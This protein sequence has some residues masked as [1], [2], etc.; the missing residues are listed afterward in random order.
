MKHFLNTLYILTPESYL[1]LQ[2]ETI[3]VKV[4]GTEKIRVP[5]HTIDSI[6]CFG[7]VT[8]STPL[9]GFFGARGIHLVFLSEYGKFHGRVQGPVSGNILL[10]RQQFA[11]LE[12]PVQRTRLCKSILLGKLVNSKLFLQRQKRER[13]DANGRIADAIEALTDA[14]KDLREAVTIESM[15]GIEGAAAA[16]YFS[17]L[18][19]MLQGTTLSFSGRTRRPPEDPVNAVLSFLYTLLKNDVQSALEGVGLDPAAGFLHTLR[20]GRPALALDMMEELRAPI[21]DRLAI[22]LLNRKQITETSFEQLH[23]PVLLNEDGRKTI[24]S[25]WQKRKQE[26]I[27]HP[28]LEETVPV[29]LIPHVQ[30]KLLARVLRGELDEYPPIVWR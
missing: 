1:F 4:G 8:V 17:A 22:A 23:A 6:Y 24:L 5:A 18:P 13:E 16:A 7:N 20:P 9:I 15:R 11:A 19:D 3:G 2:N 30:A 29:G 27:R 12:D 14:A 10:R 25:A 21:C 28:F 26:T